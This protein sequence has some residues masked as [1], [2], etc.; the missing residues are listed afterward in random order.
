MLEGGN[1]PGE[2]LATLP[3][4]STA[5]TL[6]F[7]SPAGVFY[8]RVRAFSGAS[9]SAPSNEVRLHVNVPV[10]PSAPANL[11][12]L[13]DGSTIALS[14]INTMEGGAPTSVRLNVSGSWSG[15]LPLLLGE[16]FRLTNVPAG[17]YTISVSAVNAAG[18]SPPSNAVALTFPGACSG[19]PATPRNF[20]AVAS[21]R[22]IHLAWDPPVSGAAITDYSVL[23]TGSYIGTLTTSARTLSGAVAPGTYSV[24]VIATNPCGASAPTAARTLAIY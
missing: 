7:T 22:T 10:P 15:T 2:V 11:L 3:T 13:V 1:H 14:W 9:W 12:G 21:G 8:L 19:V 5:P 23:V 20:V 6:T 17:S 24:S 4:G 18:E 16:A